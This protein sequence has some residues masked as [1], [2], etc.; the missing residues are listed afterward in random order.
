MFW[1]FIS[2]FILVLILF[3]RTDFA[4]KK[5][6]HPRW[7]GAVVMA[8]LILVLYLATAKNVLAKINPDISP[9]L[10]IHIIVA[11]TTVV[12]YVAA[13][14]YGYKL[15]TGFAEYRKQM[16]LIDRIVVPARI[17]VFITMVVLKTS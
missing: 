13:F 14:F 2:F 10:I 1:S 4:R 11:L 15:A 7:M 8:D 5:F 16:K 3:F 9:V 17:L 6:K 12:G